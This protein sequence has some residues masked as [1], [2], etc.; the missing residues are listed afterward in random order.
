MDTFTETRESGKEFEPYNGEN[1]DFPDNLH[2]S[3]DMWDIKCVPDQYFQPSEKVIQSPYSE[4]VK[5][6]H[7][8]KA[9]GQTTCTMCNGEGSLTETRTNNEGER[10]YSNRTCSYCNEGQSEC[11]SCKGCK[12]LKWFTSVKCR[13]ENHPANFYF[14]KSVL[15]KRRMKHA[16]GVIVF[17][18]M[19]VNVHPLPSNFPDKSVVK[20]SVTILSNHSNMYVMH[21]RIRR[22]KHSVLMVPITVVTYDYKE[23]KNGHFMIYGKNNLVKFNDYPVKCKVCPIC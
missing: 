13:F 10:K 21:G 1:I 14:G 7:T 20:T 3:P 5:E 11:P 15:S 22:Q 4:F 6:C 17:E 2:Q 23:R 18:D 16:K 12:R 8:C 19:D 9:T